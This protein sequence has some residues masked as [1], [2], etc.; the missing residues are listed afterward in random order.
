MFVTIVSFIIFLLV[1][2]WGVLFLTT[3]SEFD[4]PKK[5]PK[6]EEISRKTTTKNK[7]LYP[8]EHRVSMYA[9]RAM[10]EEVT[11]VHIIPEKVARH[12]DF[13]IIDKS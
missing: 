3:E 13:Q 9:G 5:E 1:F 2:W 12:G 7:W 11:T 10:D 8:E 4:A 6:I